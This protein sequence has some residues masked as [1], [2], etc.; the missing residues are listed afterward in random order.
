MKVNGGLALAENNCHVIG[1]LLVSLLLLLL[2]LL[3][4]VLLLVRTWTDVVGMVGMLGP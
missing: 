3:V 4:S 2:V 1:L